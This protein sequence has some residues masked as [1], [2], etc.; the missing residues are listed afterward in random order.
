MFVLF[1]HSTC[2][3]MKKFC[4]SLFLVVIVSVVTTAYLWVNAIVW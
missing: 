2:T 4:A 1:N 3:S